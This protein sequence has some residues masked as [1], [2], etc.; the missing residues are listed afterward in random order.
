MSVLFVENVKFGDKQMTTF[1]VGISIA[2]MA[3]TWAKPSRNLSSQQPFESQFSLYLVTSV[4]LQFAFHLFVLDSIRKLVYST[5]YETKVFN[6]KVK[7]QQNL[8]NTAMFRKK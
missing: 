7:F 6:Y 4:L 2:S 1:A 5:G 3:I 8:M